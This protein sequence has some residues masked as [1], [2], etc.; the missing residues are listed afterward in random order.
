MAFL[1]PD[2]NQG[3]PISSGLGAELCPSAQVPASAIP[4]GI[5]MVAMTPRPD[6]QTGFHTGFM[7]GFD[8]KINDYDGRANPIPVCSHHNR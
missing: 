1:L 3:N 8:R 5:R 2:Q 7:A 4:S 6:L